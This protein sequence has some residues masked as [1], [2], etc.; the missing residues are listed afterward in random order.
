MFEFS[1]E[2]RGI[3]EFLDRRIHGASLAF[4]FDR[5]L[6]GLRGNLND[7]ITQTDAVEMLAQRILALP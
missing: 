5:F 2:G 4:D 7:G 3:A 1:Q 6:A